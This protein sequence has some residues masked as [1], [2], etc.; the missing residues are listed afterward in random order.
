MYNEAQ[1]NE[2]PKDARA[3]G[4]AIPSTLSS[5]PLAAA[6]D[7]LEHGISRLYEDIMFLT[8]RLEPI[9]SPQPMNEKARLGQDRALSGSLASFVNEQT[10]RL[11]QM[12]QHVATLT[13]EL[14]I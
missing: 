14:D 7:E 2:K 10:F 4:G 5:R 9:R 6:L 1:Y 3:I 8:G 13:Q 11:E 12:H